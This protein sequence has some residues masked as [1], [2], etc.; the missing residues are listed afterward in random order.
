MKT[1]KKLIASLAV[2]AMLGAGANVDAQQYVYETGGYGYEEA[3][4]APA[5]APT[6]ALSVIAAAAIVA[7]LLQ[8]GGHHGHG[9]SHS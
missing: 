5:L 3:R 8:N 6:I 7:I 4:R 9:H 2:M 1:L